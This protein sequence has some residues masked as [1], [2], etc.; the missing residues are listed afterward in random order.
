MQE[1]SSVR[2]EAKS[3]NPSKG[4]VNGRLP[5]EEGKWGAG[6]KGLAPAL[7]QVFERKRGRH[8]GSCVKRGTGRVSS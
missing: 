3:S 5:E 1:C 4:V 2:G 8:E 7:S 6:R